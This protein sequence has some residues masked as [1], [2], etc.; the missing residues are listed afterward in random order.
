MLHLIDS[1]GTD[2]IEAYHTI[3]DELKAYDANGLARKKEIIVLSKADS[4]PSDYLDDL[5]DALKHEGAEQILVMSSVT[6][7]GVRTVLRALYSV[8]TQDIADELAKEQDDE[9][10][11]P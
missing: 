6:G 1:T 8:I 4:A 11:S 10:W 2:P 7:D 5:K 3:R 9:P